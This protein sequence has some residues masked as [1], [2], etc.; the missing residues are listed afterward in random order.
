MIL[1]EYIDAILTQYRYWHNILTQYLEI[2][3]DKYF[4]NVSSWPGQASPHPGWEANHPSPSSFT[5]FGKGTNH[6]VLELVLN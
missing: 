1:T 4:Q 6:Q 5:D 2:S 3:S